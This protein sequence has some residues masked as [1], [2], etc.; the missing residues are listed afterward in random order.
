[1]R[2]TAHMKAAM[3]LEATTA[4]HLQKKQPWAPLFSY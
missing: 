4:V 2:L 1:M 3:M